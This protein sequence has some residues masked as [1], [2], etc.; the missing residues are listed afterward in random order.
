M[1]IIGGEGAFELAVKRNEA[2][3]R[4]TLAISK[5]VRSGLTKSR[6][7]SRRFLVER[8]LLPTDLS[9]LRAEK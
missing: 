1:L 7:L 5:P 6:P 4:A 9:P 3:A 2:E 8:A